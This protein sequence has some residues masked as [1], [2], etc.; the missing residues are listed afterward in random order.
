MES[1]DSFP[2][3][4]VEERG[5]QHGIFVLSGPFLELMDKG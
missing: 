3:P 5:C 4:A 2:V 1:L